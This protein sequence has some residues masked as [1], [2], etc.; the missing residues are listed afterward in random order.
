MPPDSGIVHGQCEL[1]P[2]VYAIVESSEYLERKGHNEH[3]ELLEPITKVV[4]G[5]TNNHVTSM[6][7]LL[8]SVEA[9]VKPIAVVPDIGGP[10]NRYFVVKDRSDW[11]EC[12][13]N[14]LEE[15]QEFD[16]L[17]PHHLE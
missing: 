7:F 14:W 17:R 2:E 3:S 16:D 10:P 6:T 13:T 11:A 4:G 12:F 8:V 1:Q 9:F 15:D 5:I